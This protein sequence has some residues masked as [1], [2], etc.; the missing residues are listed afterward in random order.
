MSNSRSKYNKKNR[1]FKSYTEINNYN[2]FLLELD[3]TQS[4]TKYNKN[5]LIDLNTN[6]DVTNTIE[7]INESFINSNI[8]EPGFTGLSQLEAFEKQ[9]DPNLYESNTIIQNMVTE[10]N[11]PTS[12]T[13]NCDIRNKVNNSDTR[14]LY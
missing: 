6:K 2:N 14:T 13:N 7:N 5:N 4:Q 3:K 8:G 1:R 9:I 12:P 10:Q 11:P